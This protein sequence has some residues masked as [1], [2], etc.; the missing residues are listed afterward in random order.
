M[1]GLPLFVNVDE[2]KGGKQARENIP[3]LMHLQTK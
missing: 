1:G 2:V 3:K